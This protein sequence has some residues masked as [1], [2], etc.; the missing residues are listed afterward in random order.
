MGTVLGKGGTK[1]NDSQ[2]LPGA[3]I[4]T[5]ILPGHEEAEQ[6]SGETPVLPSIASEGELA[7][8]C[9]GRL[10]PPGCFENMGCG[11]TGVARVSY[12]NR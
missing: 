5:A 7:A 10:L 2:Y 1:V 11:L 12:S 3:N 8:R 6:E 9:F 4:G